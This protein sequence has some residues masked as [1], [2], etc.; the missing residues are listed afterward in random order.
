MHL[1]LK[2][3]ATIAF[4]LSLSL[5]KANAGLQSAMTLILNYNRF[6]QSDLP[7][8]FVAAK[9][10]NDA[11]REGSVGPELRYDPRTGNLTASIPAGVIET[12]EPGWEYARLYHLSGA[13]FATDLS[14]GGLRCPAQTS[15]QWE[16]LGANRGPLS[17]L[18]A[19]SG[20]SS[21]DGWHFSYL[22]AE[23]WGM[24]TIVAVNLD[25]G[26]VLPQNLSLPQLH[27]ALNIEGTTV[28]VVDYFNH[29]GNVTLHAPIGLTIIPESSTLIEAFI[30]AFVIA[31]YARRARLL[32]GAQC[33]YYFEP[34]AGSRN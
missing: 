21:F 24:G 1:R 2:L 6:E 25:F 13:T 14:F 32:V 22:D 9:A 27:D 17:E 28:G 20:S 16:G 30:A 3:L 11:G 33:Q 7:R 12:G 23:G 8:E 4:S 19:H 31:L 29:S 34:V 10:G 5:A 26:D 18:P 15:F